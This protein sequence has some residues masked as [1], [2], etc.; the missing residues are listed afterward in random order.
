MF[1][2]VLNRATDLATEAVNST[3]V[4]LRR[5]VSH[6]C[7]ALGRTARELTDMVWDYQDLA[8]DLRR[9]ELRDD[10]R[11]DAVVIDLRRRLG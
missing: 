4:H 5:V 1:E 7:A 10:H 9:S 6:V 11:A 3:A 2:R 8:S